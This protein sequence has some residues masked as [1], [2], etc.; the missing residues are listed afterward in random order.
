VVPLNIIVVDESEEGE[1]LSPF[2]KLRKYSAN[3][4]NQEPFEDDQF[5]LPDEKLPKGVVRR[6]LKEIYPKDGRIAAGE[7]GEDGRGGVSRPSYLCEMR[8]LPEWHFLSLIEPHTISEQ[9]YYH[10]AVVQGGRIARLVVDDFVYFDET[11]GRILC[12]PFLPD[13]PWVHII[14][15]A[16]AK[17]NRGYDRL[18]ACEPFAFLKAFSFPDWGIFNPGL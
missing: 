17:L 1:L 10:V 13:R 11:R 6:R 8:M 18:D 14:L 15:K 12:H 7:E 2:V 4:F 3:L 16:W 5:K 9:G